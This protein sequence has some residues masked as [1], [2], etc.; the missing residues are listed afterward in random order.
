MLGWVAAL[1]GGYLAGNAPFLDLAQIVPGVHDL[2]LLIP[3][4][5]L[6]L[7]PLTGVLTGLLAL[8]L[9]V[10]GRIG[11]AVLRR[12]FRIGAAGLPAGLVLLT[13]FQPWFVV[14][15]PL[16]RGRVTTSVIIAPPRTQECLPCAG[17]SD[18]QC[19]ALSSDPDAI[20]RCWGRRA[21]RAHQVLWSC[22]YLLAVGGLCCCI[23]FLRLRGEAPE[24]PQEKHPPLTAA[25]PERR[26]FLSYSRRDRDFVERLARDLT[27]RGLPVW[28][29]ARELNVGDSLP[30]EIGDA[31]AGSAWFGI[32][33]SPDAVSSRWVGL[34]LDTALTLEVET[35]TL[36]IL[37]IL[38]RSC[39]VPAP[40]RSK[41]RADFTVS[42]DDGLAALLRSLGT[43]SER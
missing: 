41:V 30:R 5:L 37:P 9:R 33:L 25:A 1:G 21:V 31:I 4:S 16:D 13:V 26:L 27:E 2:I 15:L 11:T 38:H 29:D 36:C 14:R 22:A 23:G 18:E 17:L 40:L 43:R 3:Q 28:W 34:E 19:V 8:S 7:G 20:A 6:L 12:V 39:A 35:A 24:A 42:Y 32:V 10:R